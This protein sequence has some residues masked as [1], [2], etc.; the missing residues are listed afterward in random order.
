M[1]EMQKICI[2]VTL[3]TDNMVAHIIS[4]DLNNLVIVRTD[5]V[6]ANVVQ[7]EGVTFL[8]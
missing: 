6:A 8:K 7:L 3:I 2:D 4:Q 1:K 5:R